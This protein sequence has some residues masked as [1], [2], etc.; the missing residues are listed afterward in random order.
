MN[1]L[2]EKHDSEKLLQELRG[3][4]HFNESP[5]ASTHNAAS[6]PAPGNIEPD[7]ST[8]AVI[9]DEHSDWDWIPAQE[10]SVPRVDDLGLRKEAERVQKTIGIF[11]SSEQGTVIPDLNMPEGELT[12]MQE[13][14]PTPQ[15]G[16]ATRREN[17]LVERTAKLGNIAMD[18]LRYFAD[19]P[20]DRALHAELVLGYATTD[21]NKF[22]SGSLSSYLKRSESGGWECQPWTHDVLAAIDEAG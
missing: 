16:I 9:D 18:L 2:R 1:Y 11:R 12:L 4:P 22:L 21:I 20:G 5:D 13:S 17:A 3:Q 7:F 14:S 6:H 8:E 10:T 19:N 15:Y